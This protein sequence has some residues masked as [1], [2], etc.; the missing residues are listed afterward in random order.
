MLPVT[1][2]PYGL[3]PTYFCWSTDINLYSIMQNIHSCYKANEQVNRAVVC[4]TYAW[5]IH[6]FNISWLGFD[7]M[8]FDQ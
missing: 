1:N 2:I 4:L 8:C 5:G 3:N 6:I 7:L